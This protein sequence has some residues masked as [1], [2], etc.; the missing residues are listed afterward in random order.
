MAS[1]QLAL[2][3]ERTVPGIARENYWFRRH[4]VVYEALAP[5]CRGV[6]LEA[7]CGEGYGAD[8]LAGGA[9]RVLALDYDPLAIEHVGRRYPGVTAA[10]ANLVALP[11]RD[12]VVDTV[13][14]LQV[15]EHLWDQGLFLRECRRV[16]TPG[17]ALLLS[18]PNRITFSP[19]RDTPLNPFHTRE[20]SAAELAELLVGTGFVDVVVLGL[21]HGPRLRTLDAA[22]GGSLIAAQTAA[23][24][25]EAAGA[26]EA[27]PAA[28]LRDVA[29]VTTA[30]FVLLPDD[31]GHLLD[32]SLDLV[33]TA[34]IPAESPS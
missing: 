8:L 23:V 26:A 13:V 12:G 27:W 17:G 30:D 20:L 25:A 22:H 9:T 16:L 4:L 24:L 29:S 7:G 32:A 1:D 11:V 21:H 14:S 19:G 3:G 28:I 18:T 34:R 10:L 15:V 2:T 5:Q 31:P 6:V 33:A